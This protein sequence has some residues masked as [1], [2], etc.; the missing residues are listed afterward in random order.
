L[1][2]APEWAWWVVEVGVAD[3][4]LSERIPTMKTNTIISIYNIQTYNTTVAQIEEAL[5]EVE[6]M[7]PEKAAKAIKQ[8][9]HAN[10]TQLMDN[11][12]LNAELVKVSKCR[13][14]GMP[15]N[16]TTLMRNRPA[17]F[18]KAHNI[19]NPIPMELIKACGFDYE[20]TK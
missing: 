2:L 6:Q 19:I 12:R 20:P 3:V 4:N 7:E 10:E 14:C 1:C 17:Y 18:C 9:V 16:V 15:G 8:F 11:E 5:P 13:I